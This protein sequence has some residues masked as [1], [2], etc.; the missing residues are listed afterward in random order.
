MTDTAASN[1]DP[2]GAMALYQVY[3]A[4]LRVLHDTEGVGANGASKDAKVVELLD[5]TPEQWVNLYEAE[6]RLVAGLSDTRV[7]AEAIRR[8]VEAD[9]LGVKTATDLKI[10][11]NDTNADAA[12]RKAVLATLLDDL[13]F[14]YEKR[15][16]DRIALQDA[17]LRIN[18][19]GVILLAFV[20]L[21]TIYVILFNLPQT[22]AIYHQVWVVYFGLL[23]AYFSRSIHFAANASTLDYDA[24]V[25]EFSWWAIC[26]RLLAGAIGA[27]VLYCLVRGNL[28]GGDLF[29]EHDFTELMKNATLYAGPRNAQ[30]LPLPTENFAK[31][32]V[33][34]T[35]A[36]F[37]E[38]LI[39][40]QF[41]A[42]EKKVN[43]RANQA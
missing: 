23:G 6:Q 18:W 20:A 1:K 3:R 13:H 42:L 37:S 14:R 22:A 33:W 31:L 27:L 40:D 5:K 4:G 32:L 41:A 21:P 36:G 19:T 43:D 15:R 8:F 28:V 29:P 9:K 24:S 30:Q 16:L 25:T 12:K 7:V 2:R 39:P 35:I 26:R 34:S 11:F 38:R 10:A 17:T